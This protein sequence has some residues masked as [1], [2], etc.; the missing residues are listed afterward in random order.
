MHNLKHT[1]S[2]L[3]YDVVDAVPPWQGQRAPVVFHH[4]IGTNHH[5]WAD[6]LPA[7]ATAHTCIRFDTRGYGQSPVPTPQHTFTLDNCLADLMEVVDAAGSDRVHLVGES[8]GG[9]VALLAAIRHPARVAT[10]TIS[11]AAYKGLGIQYVA[12]WRE[13][14]ASKGVPRGAPT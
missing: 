12:G 4:G 6:W 3:A 10:V 8:F 9:T 2:G 11:N 14:F 13:G 1:A 7:V 5:V